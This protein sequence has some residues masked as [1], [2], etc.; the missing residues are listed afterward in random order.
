VDAWLLEIWT[1]GWLKLDWLENIV[2]GAG[3]EVKRRND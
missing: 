3:L 2:E 1:R